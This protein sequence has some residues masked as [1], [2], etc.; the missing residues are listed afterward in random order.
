VNPQELSLGELLERFASGRASPRVLALLA[1]D[2]R[3]GARALAKRIAARRAR[4]ASELRRLRA[5]YAIERS[6]RRAGH[7][8]I[9]GVDEV[10]M[11]PL[12]GPVIAAA[13]LFTGEPRLSGLNDS[14][15]VLAPQREALAVR[16]REVAAAVAVGQATRDEIDAV[17]IYQAGLLAMRRAV[18]Q[19][20]P[21]P[22][23]IVVDARRIP[24]LA[25]AQRALVRADAQVACV[26]AASIV[27]KVARDAHMQALDARYPG[28][29]FA[30]HRGYATA[31]H[32]EALAR[33]GPSPEHRRSF[34]PVRTLQQ[35]ELFP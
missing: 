7:R 31:D 28:Y 14:K 2:P 4:E 25:V 19:L 22:D 15:Q 10:G 29:G 5:L 11:G 17:N 3:A 26:A 27:A 34:Q 35:G 8:R 24:G 9:A 33:L 32:L 1:A 16:I 30:R 20:D 13:V 21:P 23:V 18:E 6:L 12:A